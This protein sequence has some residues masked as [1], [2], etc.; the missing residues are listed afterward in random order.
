MNSITGAKNNEA[1]ESTS[2][3]ESDWQNTVPWGM[4]CAYYLLACGISWP[5]FWLARHS[6]NRP[7]LP[8]IVFT[9]GYM[10][11]PGIAA[12]L[13]YR[14][15]PQGKHITFSGTE[16][17][18]SLA[19]YLVPL[20]I[21]ATCVVPFSGLQA[22]GMVLLIGL[23]GF[24]TTCG[25]ELGWRGFLHDA[26]RSVP[27]LYR[28]LFIGIIWEL[29]HFRFARL[30]LGSE[31]IWDAMAREARFLPLT[32]LL[33]WLLGETTERSRSITVAI[34]LHFWCNALLTEEVASFV[35]SEKTVLYFAFAASAIVWSWILL[36]WKNKK[37]TAG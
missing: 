4:V 27:K 3:L 34:T 6:E 7:N 8:G 14:F 25:E 13:M 1:P 37:R 15:L 26:T 16:W 5:I 36:G 22:S 20:I 33:S 28:Y 18:R 32:I 23:I 11:G 35:G 12:I 17:K 10:W 21:L 2:S 19:F 9:L 30:F 31:T 29:W 24:V